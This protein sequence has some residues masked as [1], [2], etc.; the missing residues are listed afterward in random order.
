MEF[1][2]K[3]KIVALISQWSGS[4]SR[5]EVEAQVEGKKKKNDVPEYEQPSFILS[6]LRSLTCRLIC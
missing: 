4:T 2:N 5:T 6:E 1:N 3:K